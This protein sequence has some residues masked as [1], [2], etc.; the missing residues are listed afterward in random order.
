M[1]LGG[2]GFGCTSVGSRVMVITLFD[3]KAAALKVAFAQLNTKL[4]KLRGS[5]VNV[6][7][8][9]KYQP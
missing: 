7:E 5:K 2:K 8:A 4:L 9:V 3:E 6:G 1:S